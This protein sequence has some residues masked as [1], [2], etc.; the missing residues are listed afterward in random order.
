MNKST[1]NRKIEDGEYVCSAWFERDRSHLSLTT[2]KGRT[3]FELWD[4][5]VQEAIEDGFLTAP[6]L[7]RF[8]S[9]TA[10]S[11]SAWQPRAV[12]YA[13]SRGLIQ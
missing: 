2:P 8:N 12:E 5:Q 10:N 7:A 6:T 9:A 1:M 11:N 4:E 3:V 13:R